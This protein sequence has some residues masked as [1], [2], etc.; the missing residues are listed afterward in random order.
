MAETPN[1]RARLVE[2]WSRVISYSSSDKVYH[3]GDDNN[4]PERIKRVIHNSPTAKRAVQ[5]MSKFLQGGGLAND[6][7]IDELNGIMLSDVHRD[8]CNSIAEQYGAFIHLQYGLKDGRILPVRLKVLPY[9]ECRISKEDDDKNRGMIVMGDYSSETNNRFMSS[10]KTNKTKT[11]QRRFYPF[12]NNEDVILAQI[13][14]DAD[15]AKLKDPTLEE[16]IKTYRGQVYHLNLT[17]EYVY[18][19]SLFDSVY[20]DCDT[21]YR[22][23][24]YSNQVVRNGFLGK[25][26]VITAG[27]DDETAEQVEAD[28]QSWLGAENSGSLYHL[29]VQSPVDN[30]DSVLHIKQLESQYDDTQFDNLETR[31]RRN[32]IGAA[33]NIPSALVS[34]DEGG[35]LF[36]GSGEQYKQMKLFYYEQTEA[37]RNAIERAFKSMG[38]PVA[39]LPI[40]EPDKEIEP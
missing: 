20:N 17:P 18:A 16:M 15:L 8:V 19:M 39:I 9:G 11:K 1:I 14:R 28:V 23:S 31:I 26:A 34:S 24:L 13:K 33:N 7:T 30:I 5:M 6:Y 37:E 4:Y 22:M 21:E 36:S 12:N 32:I 3:N 38:F 35:A 27:L 40:T 29:D 2:L 25:I 10:H